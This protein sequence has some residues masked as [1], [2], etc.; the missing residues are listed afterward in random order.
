LR[1][2]DGAE[3]AFVSI[4]TRSVSTRQSLSGGGEGPHL[5]V[6]QTDPQ[7]WKEVRPTAQTFV[8]HAFG[9]FKE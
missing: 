3:Q 6:G 8:N 4:V 5:P 7:T 9:L 1:L 2:E